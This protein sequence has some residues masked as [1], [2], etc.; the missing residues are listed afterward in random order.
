MGRKS[1]L[2]FCFRA[3]FVEDQTVALLAPG[4][5]QLD[6]VAMTVEADLLLL[7]L[8]LLVVAFAGLAGQ[9]HVLALLA[10]IDGRP[11]LVAVD[12]DERAEV[13]QQLVA[14]GA[15]ETVDVEQNAL[16]RRL[17]ARASGRQAERVERAR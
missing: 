8:L 6:E 2:T 14:S 3:L 17:A 16:A 7:L 11:L 4:L 10:L 13:D 15:G 9:V 5:E 1:G 12:V